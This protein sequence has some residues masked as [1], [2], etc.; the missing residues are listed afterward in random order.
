MIANAASIIRN[1]ILQ[2]KDTMPWPPSET[3]LT[4]EKVK[5]G[6]NLAAAFLNTLLTGKLSESNSPRANPLK[7]CYGQDII[8]GVLYGKI[9]TP[10]SILLSSCI[11]SLTNCTE[12]ILLQVWA[13]DQFYN[14]R[15]TGDR[16]CNQLDTGCPD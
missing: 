7:Q 13:W 6:E 11:K 9:K 1:E 3:D 4:P 2:M 14:F 12:L 15:R 5:I 8:Y 16:I 10:E